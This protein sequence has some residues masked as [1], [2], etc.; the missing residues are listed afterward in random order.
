MVRIKRNLA[1]IIGIDRYSHIPQLK[2]A[3]FD[4]NSV[5]NVLQEKHN[6]QVFKLF[7]EGATKAKFSKLIENLQNKKIELE[8]ELIQLEKSDRLLFY[9]A[10]HGFDEESEDSEE[11]KPAGYF[12]PQDADANDNKTWL[13]MKQVYETLTNLHCHHLLMILDC[14]FAG[15]ISW[16]SKGRNVA[17]SRKLYKQNYDRFI[18]H[19]TQQ[20]IT[21][22]GHDEKAL[23]SFRFGKRGDKN[24]N[25]PFAYFLLKVLTGNCNGDGDNDKFIEAIIDDKVITIHELFTYLQNELRKVAEGQTPVLFQPQKYDPKLN[26]YIFFK[27]EYIFPLSNFK[28]EKLEEF[29]LDESTNPYKGLASFEKEDSQ[30]FYGRKKLIEEPKEGLLVKVKNYQFTVVLGLSGSGKSSLVKAGLIPAIKQEAE[31]DGQQWY[32]LETMRPGELPFTALATAVLPI[33]KGFKVDSLTQKLHQDAQFLAKIIYQWS[34]NHPNIKLVLIIDQS[35]EIITLSK[36]DQDREDFLRLLAEALAA[37]EIAE[38][39]RIVMTLRSDFEPQL[40][41]LN[42]DKYQD[43]NW[44]QVW[45]KVWQDGR[46]M[47]TPMNREE[48]QQIIEEPA[49]QRT[50]F[51]ESSKLVN[52]LID[53][54]IQMPGALPLLSF[55]LSELYLRYLKAEENQERS[56]RTITEADYQKIGGVT[57]SLTNRADNTY[58]R[59]KTEEKVDESTIRDVMLRM[60][61]TRS[62]ELA[63][64]RVPTSELVYPEPKNQQ[65]KQVIARFVEA[66]LLVKG[67]DTEGQKYVEPV[68]DALVRGWKQIKDWLDE[69]QETVE[70]V[71]LWNPIK[72]F[73]N[74]TKE[75][76]ETEK[77]LKV[78]LPLQREVNT[79]ANNWSQHAKA[80]GF[81]WNTDPRLDLLKQVLNSEDNW[82]NKVET[83]FVERSIWRKTFNT[84]RNWSIAIA[85][86]LGLSVL[87]I[88]TLISLRSTKVEQVRNL[89]DSTQIKWESDLQLEALLDLLRVGKLLDRWL[90]QLF[91]IDE[92]FKKEIQDNFLKVVYG[93][94]ELNQLQHEGEVINVN[95]QITPNGQMIVTNDRSSQQIKVWHLDGKLEKEYSYKEIKA[96]LEKSNS[97]LYQTLKQKSLLPVLNFNLEN[98]TEFF[99][100]ESKR[101]TFSP[102]GKMQVTVN[103]KR[104]V[105]IRK[106]DG[107]WSKTFQAHDTEITAVRFSPD[108]QTI[109]TGSW[110]GQI[111]LWKLDGTLYKTLKDNNKKAHYK[112]VNALDFSHDGE[113][114]AS[115][116]DDKKVKLWNQKGE[117]LR[118]LHGHQSVVWDVSISPDSKMIASASNDE[119][120][121]L[122]DQEG[123]L[124]RTFKGHND[125]VRAVAFSDNDTILAS[126]SDDGTVKLWCISSDNSDDSTVKP[127][128]PNEDTQSLKILKHSFDRLHGVIFL[129]NNNTILTARGHGNVTFWSQ[130]GTYIDTDTWHSGRINTFKFILDS[131]L[132]VSADKRGS[133]KLFRTGGSNKEDLKEEWK[134][135]LQNNVSA[136]SF[137]PDSQIFVIGDTNGK[138]EIRKR[139]GSWRKTMKEHQKSVSGLSFSRDGEVFASG[140]LDGTVKLWNKNG[141]PKK[142][143]HNDS[144]LP[145]FG[146]AFSLAQ[147]RDK[148]IIAAVINQKITPE[149][150]QETDNLLNRP[151]WKLKSNKLVTGVSDKLSEMFNTDS[152][153]NQTTPSETYQGIIKLWKIDGTELTTFIAH[154]DFVNAIAFSPDGKSIATAS[155]DQTVKIWKI[156]NCKKNDC[157]KESRTFYGHNDRVIGLAFSPDGKKI[158]SASEDKT[159]LLWDVNIEQELPALR[160]Y[161]CKWMQSYL[162]N[163]KNPEL[164]DSDRNLCNNIKSK[165]KS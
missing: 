134:D 105:S 160:E 126:A 123:K 112:S 89:I 136:V 96:I 146:V 119:T 139:D 39:L 31:T 118:T 12:M 86:M 4:A 72:K 59:L 37:T 7:D 93:V 90:L 43:T 115:A 101:Q 9:F 147:H 65:A 69:K 145:V 63:R 106:N 32:I 94:K 158:A 41:D 132:I 75:H 162:K 130:D 154:C 49:A 122:W 21:S 24:G 91:N 114:I 109:A 19:S 53:E 20:I 68:H 164:K 128:C 81:L 58:N 10:G 44:Q 161:A 151:L 98:N 127:W 50:L 103:N 67:R 27:G 5:A 29:K 143:I 150:C 15:R 144:K 78:N 108:S 45:Q 66:R 36:E 79:S 62:G 97:N 30:L 34:Q 33:T 88:S 99:R 120:V 138:I 80:I 133:V 48:L 113:I 137:S 47:V 28:P 56:D 157:K 76:P 152:K 1:I 83:E 124:L 18:K 74:G 142:T 85:V 125:V 156:D 100:S 163:N 82:F 165:V 116:S 70:T 17:R 54:V 87:T 149:T 64:R 8:G 107:S 46:F 141:S 153:D 148:Q 6:Y 110:A 61:A 13:S 111:K 135:K 16:V 159:V 140:S 84:C 42:Q 73:F 2:N 57:R 155:N 51:F 14:C 60:V 131:K 11:G 26:E 52:A 23:D 25:S 104:N 129:P 117:L 71:S 38:N 55:T 40:R 22:A 77:I 35:E 92:R 3:V 121:K 102:D 95:F